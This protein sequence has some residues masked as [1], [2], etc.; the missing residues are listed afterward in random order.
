MIARRQ[1]K[2]RT[3][4]FRRRRD[5]RD[6]VAVRLGDGVAA[7]PDFGGVAGATPLVHDDAR[8]PGIDRFLDF[9]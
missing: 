7:K 4:I 5:Q 8:V 9:A 6:Q 1:Q 3:G 2:A